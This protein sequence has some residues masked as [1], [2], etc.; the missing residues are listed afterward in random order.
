MSAKDS[1][2]RGDR[3]AVD[4]AGVERPVR[5]P[6]DQLVDRADDEVGLVGDRAGGVP[7]D[8]RRL[9]VEPG[10]VEPPAADQR[11]R[12][13]GLHGGG[14][15]RRRRAVVAGQPDQPG[16]GEVLREAQEVPRRRRRGTSRSPGPGRRSR[17]GCRPAGR[18]GA[19]ARTGRR[20]RPGTR[21]RRSTA[22]GR[23][24]AR[25]ASGSS[26]SSA[27]GSVT[28]SSRSTRSCCAQQL[29]VRGVVVAGLLP[30]PRP[31]RR[32]R[33]SGSRPAGRRRPRSP[34]GSS[35]PA[36]GTSPR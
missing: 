23:G 17:T 31:A 1:V 19:A 27:T 18:A 13:D 33:R 12:R 21:R 10:R 8:Q 24:T 34:A 32:R 20:R 7:A 14:Q 3:P 15:D 25:P 2:A 16:V 11:G 36:S 5:Q 4:P 29:A 30:G 22:S 26:R 9:R 6:A 35:G 28:S